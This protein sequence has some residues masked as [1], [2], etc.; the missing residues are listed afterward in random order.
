MILAVLIL[1]EEIKMAL[2][3]YSGLHHFSIK[4]ELI[5]GQTCINQ[6][7]TNKKTGLKIHSEVHVFP[8]SLSNV[9]RV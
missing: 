6:M 7:M 9:S 4:E 1:L 8:T 5:L 3:P 2:L